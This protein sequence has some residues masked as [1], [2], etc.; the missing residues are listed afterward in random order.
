MTI[1]NETSFRLVFEKGVSK[2]SNV[3]D[4][5]LSITRVL[6]WFVTFVIL[7]YVPLGGVFHIWSNP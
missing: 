4:E 6:S 1:N 3:M 2:P 5:I 7:F